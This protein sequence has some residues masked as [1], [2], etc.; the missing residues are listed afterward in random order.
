[1]KEGSQYIAKWLLHKKELRL[2]S[3]PEVPLGSIGFHI[4]ETQLQEEREMCSEEGG[5]RQKFIKAKPASLPK[6]FERIMIGT[7]KCN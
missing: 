1:M 7:D 4:W 3:K 5:K 6:L 2:Q